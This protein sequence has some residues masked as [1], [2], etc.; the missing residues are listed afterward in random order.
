M[1]DFLSRLHK[2]TF[3]NCFKRIASVYLPWY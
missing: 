1:K 3:A 2:T